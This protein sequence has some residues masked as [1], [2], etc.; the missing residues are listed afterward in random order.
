MLWMRILSKSRYRWLSVFGFGFVFL[1]LGVYIDIYPRWL[2][3]RELQ[4]TEQRWLRDLHGY[5]AP[6]KGLGRSQPTLIHG[7]Q[8]YQEFMFLQSL[9]LISKQSDVFLNKLEFFS[10]QSQDDLEGVSLRVAITGSFDKIIHFILCLLEAFHLLWINQFV[11]TMSNDEHFRL[12]SEIVFFPRYRIFLPDA[13]KKTIDTLRQ[14][15]FLETPFCFKSA[16][17]FFIHRVD[18]H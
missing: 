3:W 12:E 16:N 11:L 10:V 17:D 14:S 15:L 13:D 18:H 7:E 8:P 5:T 1:L 2:Q 9:F 4:Q 6:S